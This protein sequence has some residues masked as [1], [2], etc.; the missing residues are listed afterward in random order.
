ML[1]GI[2]K[3]EDIFSIHFQGGHFPNDRV[4]KDVELNLDHAILG[5]LACQLHKLHLFKKRKKASLIFC[6]RK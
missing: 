2:D 4:H 1:D 6:K 3:D 5:S